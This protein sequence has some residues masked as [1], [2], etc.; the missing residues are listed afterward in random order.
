MKTIQTK[1]GFKNVIL[2]TALTALLSG[3]VNAQPP[4]PDNN[5]Y[6]GDVHVHTG[7]SFDALTNG[8]KTTPMDAYQPVE[9]ARTAAAPYDM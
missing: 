3:T 4:N 2:A 5:V 8:S 6:F 9:K 7:W 1:S